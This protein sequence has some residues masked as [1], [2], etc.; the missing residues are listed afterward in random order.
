[1]ASV[2]PFPGY[3]REILDLFKLIERS[4][5]DEAADPLMDRWGEIRMLLFGHPEDLRSRGTSAPKPAL[6]GGLFC[7]PEL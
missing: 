4:E 7:C 1:M 5:S 2:D 3:H 6:I